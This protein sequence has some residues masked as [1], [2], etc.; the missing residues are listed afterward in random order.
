MPSHPPKKRKSYSRDAR[1]EHDGARH[2]ENKTTN[3]RDAA[4]ARSTQPAGTARAARSTQPAG[5]PAVAAFASATI[6]LVEDGSKD[7]STID[8]VEDSPDEDSPDLTDGG[9]FSNE[10]SL[11]MKSRLN[12]NDQRDNTNTFGK[13]TLKI[14]LDTLITNRIA[15]SNTALSVDN[16]HGYADEESLNN[17][18]LAAIPS[19]VAR[20]IVKSK[21]IDH[22]V[23]I[24]RVLR[25]VLSETK[26][27]RVLEH[28]I[29]AYVTIMEMAEAA[30]V[31]ELE[32][33]KINKL[34]GKSIKL[35]A[36]E[37]QRG[38]L[39]DGATKPTR[40][41]LRCPACN[42]KDT[43]HLPPENLENIAKNATIMKEWKIK[44]KHIDD[45]RTGKREDPLTEDGKV[46][47]ALPP[48][49]TKLREEHLVCK[50]WWKT[51]TKG[52]GYKCTTCTDRKCTMCKNKCRFV[53]SKR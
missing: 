8:L 1:L 51:H 7:G 9:E 48:P 40:E 13:E 43:L 16:A 39:K 28:D 3:S 36:A 37:M 24:W 22:F 38:Y 25:F 44:C 29:S 47:K 21:I 10:L 52:N 4:R 53:C 45:H 35:S 15:L 18:L 14:E 5:T 26:L 33:E 31:G 12:K 27:K 30:S 19:S 20:S 41:Y 11:N 32:A 49:T 23:R 34:N 17:L 42:T 6:D 50:A 46:V 2:P